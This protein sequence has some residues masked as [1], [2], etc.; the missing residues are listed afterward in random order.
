[1]FNDQNLGAGPVLGGRALER[2]LQAVAHAKAG[3]ARIGGIFSRGILSMQVAQMTGV[4]RNMSDLELAQIGVSRS[5]IASHAE[6]LVRGSH[7][8][9]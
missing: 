3:S 1:M 7:T 8:D 9:G 5:D 4:L 6:T 2:V